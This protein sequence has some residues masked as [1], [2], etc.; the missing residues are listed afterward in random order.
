MMGIEMDI[1]MHLNVSM[2]DGTEEVTLQ[3]MFES[4]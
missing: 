3:W 1:I 4:Y 2:P